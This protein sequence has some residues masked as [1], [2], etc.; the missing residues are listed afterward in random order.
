MNGW[1]KPL[2]VGKQKTKAFSALFTYVFF[3]KS[4]SHTFIQPSWFGEEE[5]NQWEEQQ[6]RVYLEKL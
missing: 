2:T 6:M 3:L 1:G 4:Y 5:N